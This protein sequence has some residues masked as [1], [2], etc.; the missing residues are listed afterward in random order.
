M[1]SFNRVVLMGNIVRNP[2]VRYTP[3]SNLAVGRTAIAVNRKYKEKEEVMFID[4]VFFGKQAEIMESYVTKGS[5]LLVEGRLSQ[6]SWE[7]EGQKRSKHE[8]IVDN[9]QLI[10]GR[11]DK[12]D[13]GP[14]GSGFSAS[15]DTDENEDDIPF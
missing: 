14:A 2:E 11:R 9:F 5:P 10:G 15:S 6:S 13:D 7:Q 1:A 12:N 8:I 3:G 4:L